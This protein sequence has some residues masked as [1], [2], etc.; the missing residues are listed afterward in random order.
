MAGARPLT[1][2]S[3]ALPWYVIGMTTRARAPGRRSLN[4][5]GDSPQL[6]VRVSDALLVAL[7][8]RAAHDGVTV[9]ELARRVLAD[10]AYRSD[11]DSIDIHHATLAGPLGRRLSTHR[12][13]VLDIAAAHRITNLRVFGSVARGEDRPDSDIGLLVE[14]PDGMGLLGLGRARAEFERVLD[15]RVDLIPAGDLKPDVAR[16]IAAESVPL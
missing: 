10:A 7:H 4:G 8:R 15:A 11:A 13:E 14:L 6:R 12:R 2:Y 1:W 5:A 16:T 3:L 9:S